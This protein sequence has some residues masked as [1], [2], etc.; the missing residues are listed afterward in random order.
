[1]AEDL[2]RILGERGGE[3]AEGPLRATPDLYQAVK[4]NARAAAEVLRAL[5]GM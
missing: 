5:V 4:P 1:V 3:V 2:E